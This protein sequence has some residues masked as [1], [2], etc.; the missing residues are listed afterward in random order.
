[1]GFQWIS[2]IPGYRGWPQL[3]QAIPG[4]FPLGKCLRNRTTKLNGSLVHAFVSEEFQNTKQVDLLWNSRMCC[5]WAGWLLAQ[6]LLQEWAGQKNATHGIMASWHL[7]ILSSLAYVS[8][9]EGSSLVPSFNRWLAGSLYRWLNHWVSW[10][11]ILGE[12]I[13][14]T[15]KI[16]QIC[17]S[18]CI[19]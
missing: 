14:W 19:L 13:G 10:R 6:T 18:W 1:M 12:T 2:Y 4:R 3:H 5:V 7:T 11:E 9:V 15:P 17:V 8:L 16:P